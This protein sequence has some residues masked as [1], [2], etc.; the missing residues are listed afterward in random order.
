MG[1]EGKPQK[2]PENTR[3]LKEWGCAPSNSMA[4]SKGIIHTNFTNYYYDNNTFP[5]VV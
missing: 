4:L 1:A 2:T 3:R 5:S